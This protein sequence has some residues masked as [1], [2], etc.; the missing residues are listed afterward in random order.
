MELA[1][2]VGRG[3]VVL[4]RGSSASEIR[5][6]VT[7]VAQTAGKVGHGLHHQGL[8]LLRIH[9]CKGSLRVNGWGVGVLGLAV[10]DDVVG[11]QC[12]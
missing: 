2:G 4:I 1:D 11:V 6:G 10:L 12:D 5:Q 9:A 8:E 3:S 7:E